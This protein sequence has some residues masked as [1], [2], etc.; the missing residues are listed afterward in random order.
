MPKRPPLH[1]DI[2]ADDAYAKYGNISIPGRRKKKSR[3]AVERDVET[4]LDPKTSRRIFDLAR[5]QQDELDPPVAEEDAEEDVIEND[6]TRPRTRDLELV[7]EDE[8]EDEDEQEAFQGF[9]DDEEREFEIDEGDIQAIDALHSSNAGDRRTLADLIFSK[10][11]SGVGQNAVIRSS[12]RS[13][14]DDEAPDP[15]EG[16]DPKVV[17][18][19]TKVGQLLRSYRAGPL[20][21]PFKIIPSLPAWA[22]ILALT[23][24]EQWS[25]QATHAATRI[26][27]SNMKP[28]QARVFLEGVVL[29][30]VRAGL[31]EPSTRKDTRKLS[32]HL[33]EALKRALY[34]PAAF[35]KGIVFP[36]LDGG[37]TLKE[38]AIVASVLAKVKVPL[39]H[40]SAAL[41]RLAGMD[42]SGPTSLF[43][44]VL[45]D[46]K[47]ALPYKVLDAL[48]FHFI[49][50]ANTHAPGT[51]PVLWHQSLLVLCQ[52]YAAHL[53]PE[54]KDALRDIVRAHP[55]AQISPE[56]RRE[57]TAAP[58]RGEAG[59]AMDVL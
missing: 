34:K 5:D 4:I 13:R 14:R 49:R 22:R 30:L 41:I 38:A 25:P 24:P 26:F 44:R 18:V 47:H 39:L 57:L 28:P 27:I 9:I 17:E 12:N 20:P 8:D 54:Q 48:V 32:P 31:E 53:A 35:F 52:R 40:A 11:E 19:Y 23:T 59:D 3:H 50:L 6:F 21:K 29:G 10:L 45:L 43:I 56:V 15:A 37:C 1:L 55:H 16:L 7:D 2:A 33:Y 36:L 51:L 46:K 42:Y 58:A